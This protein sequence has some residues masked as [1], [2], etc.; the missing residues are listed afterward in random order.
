MKYGPFELQ[1]EDFLPLDFT[2]VERDVFVTPFLGAEGAERVLLEVDR[3]ERKR[4]TASERAHRQPSSMHDHGVSLQSLGM[5]ALVDDLLARSPGLR[6]LLARRFGSVGGDSI[7]GHYSYLVDYGRSGDEDLGFHVDDSEVTLNLCLGE[8]FSGSELVML[9]RRCD[10][11]RQTPVRSGETV[12]ILH[13]PGFLVVHA[14]RHRHRVDPIRTGRR[15]NLIAWL[16]SS[17]YRGLD[18]SPA[19]P[20][21]CGWP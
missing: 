1:P 13:E 10:E 18:S 2:E 12:E 16:R 21:W 5:E 3:R 15:R 7:D 6:D 17:S 19:C 8:T 4:A 20:D 9:G 14:G 11:H